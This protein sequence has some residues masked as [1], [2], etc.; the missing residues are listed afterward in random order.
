MATTLTT[1]V[2]SGTDR[3]D[4]FEIGVYDVAIESLKIVDSTMYTNKDGTPKQ[5]VE[6]QCE[7]PDVE[8]SEGNTVTTK[9]WL[10]AVI[11]PPNP[12]GKSDNARKGSHLWRVIGA[13]TGKQLADGD[14]FDLE[15]L[16]GGKFRAYCELSD[17]GYPRIKNDTIASGRKTATKA[18]APTKPGSPAKAAPPAML[19]PEQITHISDGWLKG[20]YGDVVELKA[21]VQANYDGRDLDAIRADE[22]AGVCEVL[23]LAPF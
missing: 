8:D 9:V 14:D 11:L 1:S 13:V 23:E 16:V 6:L 4:D 20:G 19:T 5:Q 17:K 18:K 12:T 3:F 7:L 10:N 2:G 15:E 22:Y 21:W